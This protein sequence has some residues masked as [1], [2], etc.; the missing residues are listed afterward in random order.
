[1]TGAFYFSVKFQGDP[2]IDEVAFQEVAGLAAKMEM[3]T[4]TEGGVNDRRLQLPK[5]MSHDNV[6]LKRAMMPREGAFGKW[7]HETMEGGLAK[8]I[9][10]RNLE[11]ALLDENGA[12]VSSWTCAGA[13]PVKWNAESFNSQKNELA[14]ESI[15]LT[16]TTLT[17]E[18]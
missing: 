8:P 7:I 13:W 16:Y 15:E 2:A 5:G 17:R 11:I 9:V 6:V 10:P 12:P 14:V 18:K 4:V 3:E 1:M